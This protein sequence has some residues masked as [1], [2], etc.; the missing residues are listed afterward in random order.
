VGQLV[1]DPTCFHNLALY[2]TGGKKCTAALEP[3]NRPIAIVAKGCDS[4]AIMVLLQENYIKRES[5]HVLGVSCEGTGVIDEKKLKAK[6][7][8]KLALAVT[9]AD[10]NTYHVTTDEG[11]VTVT[12]KDVMADRCLECRAAYPV[13]HDSVFGE[14]NVARDSKPFQGLKAFEAEHK[15]AAAYEFW[16]RTMDRC[17]R[18]YACRS[19]CPMC[20]CDECV[21][22][23]VEHVVTADTTPDQKA[24]RINW[25]QKSNSSSETFGYHLVRAMHLAGRC[26]DC[27]ECERVCPVDI[28]LRLLNTKLERE[29]LELFDYEAGFDVEKPSLV[30]S[31]NDK[32]PNDFIR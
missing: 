32:D 21:V 18:C 30:S 26:V 16:H 31:F 5:V 17:L 4:R 29:T 7:G 12:A 3:D 15:G 11:D 23:S 8:H 6:L 24:Q 27:G 9:F 19:V 13:V 2:L 10:A 14:A 22:D 25:I 28:P 1:W 20:Y